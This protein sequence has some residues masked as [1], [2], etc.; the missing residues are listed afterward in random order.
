MVS[1][2]DI[3]TLLSPLVCDFEKF[4]G[5]CLKIRPKAEGLLIPFTFNRVQKFVHE[6]LEKQKREKGMVRALVLKYRQGGIST[7]IE[8]RFYHAAALNF[9]VN[10]KI[11][12]HQQDAT[13]N[14]FGMAARFHQHCPAALRPHTKN[15]SAKE[16]TFDQMGSSFSVATTGSKDTGRSQTEQR[17]HA[18]EVAFW[19]NAT[20]HMAGIGQIVPR[21]PGTEIIHETTGN[22]IGN[23]FHGMWQDAV[24]GIGDYVAIFAPWMLHEDYRIPVPEGFTLDQ[25]EAEYARLHGCDIEQMVWRRA[26]IASDFRGDTALFDQEYPAT[27]ELAFRRVKGDP[28]IK[29]EYVSRA[30]KN[31]K[32][33]AIGAKIMGIDPAEFGD[34][35]TSMT[36]RQGRVQT[37]KWRKNGLAPMEVVGMACRLMDEWKPDAANID[38]TGIGSGI[39][40]R[41]IEL[42]YKVN[43]VHFGARAIRGEAGEYVLRRD[44]M[45]GEMRDW[46]EDEPVQIFDDDVL[47]ADLS[48]PQYTYDSSRRLKLESKKEMQKRGISSPDDGDA[49][50]LTFAMPVHPMGGRRIDHNRISPAW[51]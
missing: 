34:N 42:G 45:W 20:E 51:V 44:E 24:R 31:T 8:G 5:S 15:E 46:F 14:L 35:S 3:K 25:D 12:T 26:K 1:G 30:R 41:M 28:L 39:A 18:S 38:C 21:L 7:Y 32:V 37:K 43:R 40:D 17:F 50:A 48:G 22:G 33:E 23:L 27:P 29:P 47:A 4:A 19:A 9:G 11:L 16:L 36:L 2:E 13:D 49:F 10:V 6:A